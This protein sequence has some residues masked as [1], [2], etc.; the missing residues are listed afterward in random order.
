[1]PA[2]CL[3]PRLWFSHVFAQACRLSP[4]LKGAL[5]PLKKYFFS[6]PHKDLAPLLKKFFFTNPAFRVR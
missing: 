2:T 5:P 1:M 6:L 3:P 4:V